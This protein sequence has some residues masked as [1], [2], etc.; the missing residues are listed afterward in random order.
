MAAAPG[1]GLAACG[2]AAGGSPPAAPCS[3]PPL[4][5]PAPVPAPAALRRE[6]RPA[7]APWQPLP[8]PAPPGEYGVRCCLPASIHSAGGGLGEAGAEG[9]TDVRVVPV[10]RPEIKRR[11]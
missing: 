6:R 4:L 3:A 11:D 9:C 8:P 7:P 1:A 2:R 5:P 10:D